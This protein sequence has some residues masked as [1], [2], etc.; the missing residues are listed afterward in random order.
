MI[1]P[2]DGAADRWKELDTQGTGSKDDSVI[3]IL[4]LRQSDCSR[5]R[6]FLG[7]K[8]AFGVASGIRRRILSPGVPG[9]W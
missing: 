7:D 5:M 6:N 1:K 9:G 3:H 8:Y 4:N 2:G